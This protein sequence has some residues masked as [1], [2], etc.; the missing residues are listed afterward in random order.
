M[1][2]LQL[3]EQQLSFF[4]TFGFL[5][6]P[7]LMTDTIEQITN[8]FEQIWE[9]RG[10]GH[11]GK[12]HDGERRSCIVPFIDQHPRLSALID[13][14]R[15]DGI[16]SSLL[17]VAYNYAGSD[18][19]YYAG[20][21]VWHSDGW[22]KARRFVKIAFYLDELNRKTG[23][24]R[25]IPGSHKLEDRFAQSLQESIRESEDSW[26]MSGADLLPGVA[27]ETSPGDIVL[28][29]HNLKHASFGGSGRR[30]MFTINCSQRFAENDIEDPKKYIEGHARFWNDRAYGE[31]MV[32]TAGPDRMVHL[33]Q[34]LANDGHLAPLAAKARKE[35]PEPSRG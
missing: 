14:P 5:A 4:D 11:D 10:G 23:C 3:S 2:K 27:L 26:G 1:E 13:D 24:L 8:D 22:G 32:R 25:V 12:P 28:F 31:I 16:L 29:N 33:E 21:T 30:R 7:G 18:G 34:I 15:I 6:F 19:N 17:G 35:M 9:E 20:D